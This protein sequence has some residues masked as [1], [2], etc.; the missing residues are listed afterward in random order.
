MQLVYYTANLGQT[1]SSLYKAVHEARLLYLLYFRKKKRSPIYF[2][3][4]GGGGGGGGGGWQFV[5]ARI[6]VELKLGAG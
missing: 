1:W 3:M 6:G 5:Y 4:Y 2:L